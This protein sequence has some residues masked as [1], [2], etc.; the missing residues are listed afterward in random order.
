MMRDR[1]LPDQIHNYAHNNEWLIRNL[2]FLGR[3]DDAISLA[4]NMIELPRH[5]Q[6]NTPDTGSSR[7]GTQ[8]LADVLLQYERWEDIVRYAETASYL[9]ALKKDDLD[10]KLKRLRLLGRA[11]IG[12][13][14]SED[15]AKQIAA[16][17]ALLKDERAARYQA[18]DEAEAKA[19]ADKKSNK[20]VAKAMADALAKNS[21]QLK[22]IDNLLAELRGYA[23]LAADK[24]ADAK[25]EFEKIKNSD[26]LRQDH[27]AHAL[28]LTG[29]HAQAEK[30][31]RK[32][33]DDGPNEVYPLAVLI[34]VLARAGKKPAAK[35]E[36][37]KLRLVAADADL[38]NRVFGRLRPLADELKLPVDWRIA[39][40]PSIDVG[41]RPDLESLGPFRWQ[42]TPATSWTLSGARDEPVSLDDYR[43]KPV[44]VIFYLGSG[45]LHCVEQ[46]QKFAPLASKF[47]DARIS[48]VAIS[49]EPLDT[50]QGSLTNLSPEEP[51]PFPLAADPELAVFKDYRAYDDFEAMPLHGTYLIDAQG[52]VRW[53]DI[54]YEPFNDAEFLLG[55]AQ[56]LLGTK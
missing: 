16:I 12:L 48:L 38:D 43:G 34:D 10:E 21:P 39:R 40:E 32:A 19:R 22:K 30:I 55:E 49:S 27:L 14:K 7:Y 41:D 6:Y 52:L 5:P 28:S 1:V 46:L 15:G 33:A 51:I 26:G 11:L 50:L 29:D 56:R 42:P 4:T 2:A 47:A 23:A 24:P 53:H 8:R 13:G 17:E 44:V 20:D 37:A 31:A 3:V 18:A 45:C 9:D 36:F 25:A 35:A 54:S